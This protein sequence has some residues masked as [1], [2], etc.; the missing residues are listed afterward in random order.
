L[1]V[2]KEASTQ[3]MIPAETP[4]LGGE[5]AMVETVEC[6]SKRK[7]TN[8]NMM[9]TMKEEGL[10]TSPRTKRHGQEGMCSGRRG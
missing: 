10:E 5:S 8:H 7:R 2:I 4:L 9:M 1:D 6:R 3:R